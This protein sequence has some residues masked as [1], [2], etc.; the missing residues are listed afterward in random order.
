M[1]NKAIDVVT[2]FMTSQR[3]FKDTD[4]R[5]NWVEWALNPKTYPFRYE[6]VVKT[7]DGSEVR[8]VS[9]GPTVTRI[10]LSVPR[11]C[12]I[13][14]IQHLPTQAHSPNTRLPHQAYPAACQSDQGPSLQ[15]S[16]PCDHCS[17][18]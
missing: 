9:L 14:K 12:L 1:G 5:M 13:E 6:K 18:F 4:A 2:K 7:C 15:R 16:S 11:R 8:S 3:H 17:E 10:L